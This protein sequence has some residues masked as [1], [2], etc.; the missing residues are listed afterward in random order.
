[1]KDFKE[2]TR[3]ELKQKIDRKEDFILIDTLG[4]E[5]YAKRHLP[6]TLCI[7]AHKDDF[8]EQV[9]KQILDK[10]KEVIVYCASFSCQLS[11]Y[12]AKKLVEAGY[13]NVK[14]FEG[15]LKDWEEA[16]YSFES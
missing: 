5:S 8:V 16:G 14:D 3:E 4:E 2:I 7:D 11:P 1:M 10:N 6:G 9:E 12:V 15:G 13:T